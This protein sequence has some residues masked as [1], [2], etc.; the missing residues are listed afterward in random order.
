MD[1]V[2]FCKSYEINKKSEKRNRKEQKKMGKRPQDRIR[3]EPDPAHGPSGRLPEP[4]RSRSSATIGW[5]GRPI[6]ISLLLWQGVLDEPD[7]ALAVN[8]PASKTLAPPPRHSLSYKAPEP[9]VRLLLFP[10]RESTARP[11]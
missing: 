7:A 4:V 6:R 11:L 2:P 10:P 8:R 1:L 9:L 5:F 3:P